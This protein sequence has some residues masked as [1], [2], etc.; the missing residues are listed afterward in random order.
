MW[1]LRASVVHMLFLTVR[2][3]SLERWGAVLVSAM[4]GSL[5]NIILLRDC[6]FE[7]LS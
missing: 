3:E 6:S 5:W 4:L 1:S 2:G 7:F